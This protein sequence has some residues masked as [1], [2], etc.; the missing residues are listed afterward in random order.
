MNLALQHL[1]ILPKMSGLLLLLNQ[2]IGFHL[3]GDLQLTNLSQSSQI[4]VFFY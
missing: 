2:E 3:Q 1:N 4:I